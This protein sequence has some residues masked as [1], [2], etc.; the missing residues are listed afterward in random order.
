ME[1]SKALI[2]SRASEGDVNLYFSI[3]AIFYTGQV[4]ILSYF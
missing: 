3:N 2:M 4:A 1:I